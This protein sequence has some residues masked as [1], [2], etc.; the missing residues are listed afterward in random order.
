MELFLIQATANQIGISADTIRS[1]E[2]Q[3]LIKPMRDSAQRRLFTKGDI[4]K[5]REIYLENQ[6]KRPKRLIR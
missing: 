2:K 1:Y 5:I 4:T 3:G 6:G